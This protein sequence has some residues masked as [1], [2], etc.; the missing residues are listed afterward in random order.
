MD[1]GRPMDIPDS[2]RDLEEL[3]E[4]TETGGRDKFRQFMAQAEYKYKIAM[5]DYVKRPSL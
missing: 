1:N 2:R 4:K 5:S 3:F